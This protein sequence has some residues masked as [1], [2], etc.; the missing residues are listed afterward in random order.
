[1]ARHKDY[2]QIGSDNENS[3][4][5]VA[6]L[7]LS[8]SSPIYLMILSSVR[9]EEMASEELSKKLGIE[10]KTAAAK[11]KSMERMGI[12]ASRARS[13]KIA[14]RVADLRLL[15]AFDRI[16]EIPAKRLNKA[17]SSKKELSGI[18]QKPLSLRKR[19][20]SYMTLK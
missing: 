16:L 4:L 14:Y 19:V 10:P 1:M 6:D 2:F 5:A 17:D 9:K 7:F 20:P 15:E 12:L 3:Y 18:T 13:H 11:L 8:L